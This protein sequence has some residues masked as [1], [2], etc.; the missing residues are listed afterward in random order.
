MEICLVVNIDPHRYLG[1]AI[2]STLSKDKHRDE[3]HECVLC[4]LVQLKHSDA[5]TDQHS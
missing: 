3:G 5:L 2:E 1:C 4:K